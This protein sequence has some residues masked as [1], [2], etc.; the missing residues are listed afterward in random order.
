MIRIHEQRTIPMQR[1]AA[2]AFI[3]DFSHVAEWDPGITESSKA[4]DG[5]VGVGSEFAVVSKFAGRPIPLTYVVEEWDAPN[6]VLLSAATSSFAGRDTITFEDAPHGTLVDYVAEFEFK[7]IM[8]L[9]EPFLGRTFDKIGREALD[10]MVAAV[11]AR[12]A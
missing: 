11:A 4:S 1:D 5:P 9:A 8:R 7:G 6:R 2:F 10:G 12:V 3:A